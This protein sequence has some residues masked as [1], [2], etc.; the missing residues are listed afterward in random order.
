MT[1]SAVMPQKLTGD[2]HFIGY[3]YI[4]PNSQFVVYRVD[5]LLT[6]ITNLYS[7]PIDG[8]ST[9][10]QLNPDL[11]TGGGVGGEFLIT[12]NSQRVVFKACQDS[13]QQYKLF[14]VYMDG[15]NLKK[16][17]DTLMPEENILTFKITPNG[18]GVVYRES[19]ANEIIDLYSDSINGGSRNQLNPPLGSNQWVIDFEI[20]P[21]NLGVVYR[22]DQD[23]DEVFEL[24]SVYING[25]G[26][27]KLNQ[28]FSSFQDVKSDY[29][30]SPN[31][32][33]VVYRADIEHDDVYE[34]YVV[35]TL[36]GESIKLNEEITIAGGFV[37]SFRIAPDNRSIVYAAD[38]EV[39]GKQELY[40]AFNAAQLYIPVV[41]R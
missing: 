3:Y 22:A 28:S 9:P 37:H 6:D 1:L 32:L 4:S 8:S 26:P 35:P 7:V 10:K 27:R 38:L 39:F 11:D 18:L 33:A 20:T 34:L 36:G 14:S 13:L 16:L 5:N 41:S 2:D 29:R 19:K 23:V 15:T 21:N 12:P 24:Y 31:S 30:I 17:T 40:V 25:E